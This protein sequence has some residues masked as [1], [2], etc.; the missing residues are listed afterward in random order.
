MIGFIGTCHLRLTIHEVYKTWYQTC[1][2]VDLSVF[3]LKVLT[4]SRAE[5]M[6]SAPC[7]SNIIIISVGGGDIQTERENTEVAGYPAS[8]ESD[9]LNQECQTSTIIIY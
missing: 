5:S 2:I 1:G 6:A 8:K 9:R 7:E 4:S 3:A